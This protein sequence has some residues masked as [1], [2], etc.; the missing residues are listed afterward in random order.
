MTDSERDEIARLRQEIEADRR[1]WTRRGWWA[2]GT[3][4]VAIAAALVATGVNLNRLDAV[5]GDVEK[6]STVLSRLAVLESSAIEN[7]EWRREVNVRLD[8]IFDRL[9]RRETQ[10]REP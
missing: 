7:R 1:A 10:N 4:G 5:E 8:R 2:L 6:R 9:P 3:F